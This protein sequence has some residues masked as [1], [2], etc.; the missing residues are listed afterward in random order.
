MKTLAARRN[1]MKTLTVIFA[2]V[3]VMFAAWFF[4]DH[5]KR[6]E[7]GQKHGHWIEFPEGEDVLAAKGHYVNGKR[8]GPWVER[9]TL[10][11]GTDEGPYVDGKKHG[12]WVEKQWPSDGVQE[13]AY[14]DGKKHGYWVWRKPD[15]TEVKVNWRNGEIVDE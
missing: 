5:N 2:I 13:G 12:H 7:L 4:A 10:F 8:H 11:G 6:D 15:G 14:V 1:A 3:A 9:L